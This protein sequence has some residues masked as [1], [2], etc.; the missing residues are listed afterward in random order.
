MFTSF[1]SCVGATLFL[2][3]GPGVLTGAAYLLS[4][5]AVDLIGEANPY[6]SQKNIILMDIIPSWLLLTI[7]S[8]LT[9]NTNTM[10]LVQVGMFLS[11]FM[12]Y[13]DKGGKILFGWEPVFH[14]KTDKIYIQLN[15]L[16][17]LSINI[18][19]VI[20]MCGIIYYF[21]R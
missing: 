9:K 8:V 3:P 19:S 18:A 20:L 14:W 5:K 2:I 17:T 21:G 16:Q 1:H 4:H 15:K 10:I 13:W 12:D 11:N 6:G 7:A